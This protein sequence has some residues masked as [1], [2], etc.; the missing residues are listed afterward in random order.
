MLHL[1]SF[2]EYCL[3]KPGVTEGL[4]FGP[5]VLVMKVGGK[6]FALAPLNTPEMR[7]NLKCDP[8]DALLLRDKYPMHVLPGY[9]MNKMNWNT[10]IVDG[11]IPD[12]LLLEWINHSYDLILA[13][14]PAKVRKTIL[15]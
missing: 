12:K 1:E 11:S 5:D 6:M 7:M 2:R 4:P 14:L 13:S 9:H 10:V 15:P 8:E 3:A